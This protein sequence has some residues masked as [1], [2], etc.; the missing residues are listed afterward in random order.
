M[1]YDGPTARAFSTEGVPVGDRVSF[2][3]RAIGSTF[4]A[5]YVV[6][7][8]EASPLEVEIVGYRGQ[9]LQFASVR[10][11][12]HSGL[13]VGAPQN[14]SR[15]T[16]SLQ[17]EGESL[18]GQGGREYRIEPGDLVL[19]D[20]SRPFHFETGE[21]RANVLEFPAQTLRSLVPQVDDLVAAP[22]RAYEGAAALFRAMFDELFVIAPA[23]SDEAADRAADALPHVLAAAIGSLEQARAP[24]PSALKLLHKQRIRNFV[25]DHLSDPGLDVNT[26]ADGVR[27]S[28][29]YIHQ[30]F[31]DEPTTLM[32]WLWAERLERCRSELLLPPLRARSISEIAYGWGFNDLAHF[33]RAFRERF[34][35]SPRELRKAVAEPFDLAR[36]E[37][38]ARSTF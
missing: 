17:K 13:A 5:R 8:L 11:S 37:R 22:F 31:A 1:F 7:P 38:N 20:P 23:L 24:S 18:V 32:K 9:R 16:V 25:L 15:F 12:P 3:E 33:S 30:L 19:I 14:R 21:V 28:P 34:G 26:I 36:P 27:L 29:R 10:F 35:Q 6:K 2:Y 4:S